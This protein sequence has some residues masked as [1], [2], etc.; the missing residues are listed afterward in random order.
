MELGFS[1][2]I[3]L[4]MLLAL[5]LLVFTHFFIFRHIKKRA[6]MFA[7][8][9]V[10]KRVTGEG[11]V[12]SRGN[13][14]VAK[15][16][17]LLVLR[18]ITLTL[19]VITLSGPFIIYKVSTNLGSLV[20][21]VD[22]SSSMLANDFEP[23]RLEAAKEALGLF[24]KNF[25]GNLRAGLVSFSGQALVELFI[26]LDKELL[27][28]KINALEVSRTGGTDIGA[29]IVTSVNLL[30]KE[31]GQKTVLLVTDGRQ[32]VGGGLEEAINYALTNQ[33]KVNTIGMGT[34]TGGSFLNIQSISTLD[35]PSLIRIAN[36]TGGHY[37]F[38]GNP[39]ELV[40]KISE[41]LGRSESIKRLELSQYFM[42]AGIFFLILEWVL[43]NTKYRG[44]P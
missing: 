44:I 16:I 33:V 30:L 36:I 29:A 25:Q 15:N 9:E 1:N 18:I 5:P 7:N 37:Y 4:L 20:I 31:E 14:F 21:A 13:T 42:A 32:T 24:V 8:F 34:K 41:G 26:G 3:W 27:L 28:E 23:N 17:F 39:S 6:F 19:L 35:E 38:A 22:T 2:P 10:I 12:L 40:N 43:A 11:F